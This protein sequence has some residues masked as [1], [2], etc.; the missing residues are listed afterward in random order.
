MGL[1]LV[2]GFT[3]LAETRS[4][5][6]LTV[7]SLFLLSLL[8]IFFDTP[9]FFKWG[10]PREIAL[11]AGAS[12]QITREAFL[13]N[14]KTFLIGT[15][16]G[17]FKQDFSIYRT[18][19]YNLIGALWTYRFDRPY[20]S[21]FGLLVEIGVLGTVAFLF[22]LMLGIGGI[23]AAWI[24]TRPSAWEKIKPL[25]NQTEA[26]NNLIRLEVFV[27]SAALIAGTVGFCI[28]FYDLALWWM[29]WLLFGLAAVGTSV[30]IPSL[31]KERRVSL[32]V[33]PQYALA[34]S[35]GVVLFFTA[36]MVLGIFG[37]R[38]YLAE[39]YYQ[40]A[41]QTDNLVFADA[42][43]QKAIKYHPNYA[44]Y[45]L[46][47]ALNSLQMAKMES[48]K[49]N[50]DMAV[51][52]ERV[53]SAINA[54]RDATDLWPNDVETWETRGIMYLNAQTLA[55]DA[56]IWAEEAFRRG[57]ELEPTNPLL[58]WRMGQMMEMNKKDKEAED[59]Y[60]KA[61]ELKPDFLPAYAQLSELLEKQNRLDEAIALYEPI[62]ETIKINPEF[63]FN[64]GRLFY[65]R[66]N[67][68][69][70][71]RAEQVWLQSVAIDQNYSNALYS[72]GLLYE[73]IGKKSEA[74]KYFKKVR[75]LNPGNPDIGKKI[76]AIL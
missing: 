59:A 65:N 69:D 38:L 21:L 42:Y 32:E 15:G 37:S 13:H 76:E 17:T 25:N 64:L 29:W 62:F 36:L 14:A 6:L 50:P 22:L 63:L 27:L 24:K 61:I 56:T 23:F 19:E 39:V 51:L 73:K 52:G 44:P 72:L 75:E 54:S 67:Q 53:S 35:F 33:S 11:G 41:N 31:V 12:W 55:P 70:W 49:A 20:N 9:A 1:L 30:F 26:E 4:A 10:E 7:F 60:K 18:P 71:A 47:L 48:D 2:V 3:V 74:V 46:T 43:L 28:S 34:A 8:L 5:I 58:Y 40:K 16:P 57:V 45:H 68:G 66:N